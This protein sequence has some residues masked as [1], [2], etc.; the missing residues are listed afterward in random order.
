M[1]NGVP[2]YDKDGNVVNSH[3]AGIIEEDGRYYLFGEYKQDDSNG[4]NGFSCYSTVDFEK[5]KYEGMA[6]DRD[7]SERLNGGRVGERVKV[8]RARSTGKYVMMMHTDDLSYSDPCICYATSDKIA[9][10]YDFKGPLLYKGEIIKRW[11]MGSYTDD[12]ETSY[13]LTHEGYVYRL[14]EDCTEAE[15][16][17][18]SEFAVGGESPAMTK[19]GDTYFIMFS[20][21]TSWERNDNYYFTSKSLYGPWEYRGLFCPEGTNTYNTQCSFLLK[22]RIKGEER[23]LYLGDRWSYPMQASAATLVI[24]PVEFDGDEMWIEEYREEIY[25]GDSEF[26]ESGEETTSSEENPQEKSRLEK[27]HPKNKNFVGKD[28]K[29]ESLDRAIKDKSFE[30]ID[31]IGQN[32][33]DCIEIDFHGKRVEIYGTSKKNGGYAKIEIKDKD[34]KTVNCQIIDFYSLVKNYGIR[35]VSPKLEEG[36][37]R[38]KIECLGRAGEWFNKRGNRFGSTGTEVDVREMRV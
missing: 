12:D 2:W 15:E 6:L 17:L 27:N 13:L 34:D 18:C 25:L 36:D 26:D 33:G 10:P 24:L 38:L 9:G 16:L 22:T 11:D 32:K 14:S 23:V 3:G 5:W 30:K 29:I 8:V 1:Y 37:Y 19:H 31:F 4:Y 28:Y 35:Y 7:V 20:N 21:K